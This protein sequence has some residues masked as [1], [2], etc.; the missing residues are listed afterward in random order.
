MTIDAGGLSGMITISTALTA[1]TNADTYSMT[2]TPSADF[3]L[4]GSSVVFVAGTAKNFVI[5]PKALNIAVSKPY[6]GNATFTSANTI[7]LTGMANSESAPTISSGSATVSSANVTPSPVTTFATNSFAL[8]NSNYTLTGGTVSAAITQL[9]SVTYTGSSGGLWSSGGNW[10]V[11]GGVATGATPTLGNVATVV[12]PS[13][14]SVTYSDAMASSTPTSATAITNNGT[15]A[16]TNTSAVTLPTAITGG[17]QLSLSGSAP[18]ILSATNGY[19]GTTTINEGSTLQAG[20]TGALSSSSAYVID[21]TLDLA[22]N[23]VSAGSIAGAS[24]GV[25]TSTVAG[26]PVL[27]AGG[28]N[29]STTYAGVIQNGIATVGLTKT[30]SGTLILSG[31]NTH[32]GITSINGGTLSVE[33]DSNLGSASSLE[34]NAGT[35]RITGSGTFTSSKNIT[36]NGAHIARTVGREVHAGSEEQRLIGVVIRECERIDGERPR[37]QTP[38]ASGD[39]FGNIWSRRDV[40]RLQ[41][42]GL[43]RLG[44]AVELS[45][46]CR[47]TAPQNEVHGNRCAGLERE[48]AGALGHTADFPSRRVELQILTTEHG[49]S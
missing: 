49:R 42:R 17:G 46:G 36:M 33:S 29:T 7:I 37:L 9:A 16:F 35:L 39:L 32:S 6:D 23:S 19:S 44:P 3:A 21:G 28:N 15:I 26:T 1:G 30:G 34:M 10:T 4:S 18:L 11:T 38:L 22:G 8:S 48:H 47:G 27:T 2:L 20:S 40:L 13:G 14:S 45:G 43:L 24:T 31:T 12:I 41:A 25:V 5:N